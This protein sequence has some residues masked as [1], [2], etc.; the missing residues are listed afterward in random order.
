MQRRAQFSSDAQKSLFDQA[1]FTEGL[2]RCQ[3]LLTELRTRD[4]R[5][6]DIGHLLYERAGF[7]RM[8]GD[9]DG[10]I[11]TM[12]ETLAF[13]LAT[14]GEVSW[15]TFKSLSTLARFNIL[16]GHHELA[17]QLIRRGLA[18]LNQ[19]PMEEQ[20]ERYVFLM[21]LADIYS[22]RGQLR[23][24]EL[25]ILEA[26]RLVGRNY[27]ADSLGA[28][29]FELS[30]IY[31][32]QHRLVAARRTMQKAIRF[33][34]RT[35]RHRLNELKLGRMYYHLG[36]LHQRMNEPAE[37]RQCF[38]ASLAVSQ[39]FPPLDDPRRIRWEKVCRERLADLEEA[40]V[41]MP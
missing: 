3:E 12:H 38:A 18:A 11:A 35:E 1:K 32:R 31:M 23:E 20:D 15:N 30:W 24:A 21:N 27:W 8:S 14:E 34:E 19:L 10:A 4:P 22:S 26:L 39:S 13:D 29:C 41:T 9:L 7:Q 33:F 28:V 25:Q 16:A 5:Q 36:R 40:L 17:E 6:A 37:A 2:V